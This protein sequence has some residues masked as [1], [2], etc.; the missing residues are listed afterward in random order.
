MN[1]GPLPTMPRQSAPPYSRPSSAHPSPRNKS[2]S[3]GCLAHPRLR[4]SVV[5]PTRLVS[6]SRLE[7]RGLDWSTLP[8]SLVV[9]IECSPSQPRLAVAQTASL[10]AILP[11]ALHPAAVAYP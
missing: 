7:T 5:A 8:G 9:G 11:V 4:L 2:H 10:P 6:L 3:P 1:P